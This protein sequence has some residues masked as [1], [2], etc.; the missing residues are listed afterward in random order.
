MKK[1]HLQ[2][3]LLA[4]MLW[5]TSSVY[6]SCTED[7]DSIVTQIKHS[8]HI[9]TKDGYEVRSVSGHPWTFAKGTWCGVIGKIVNPAD[10]D[11]ELNWIK[12][13]WKQTLVVD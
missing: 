2:F 12:G 8:G 13:N 3:S 6:A 7:F 1:T 4:L 9:T 5:T 11:V 10:P